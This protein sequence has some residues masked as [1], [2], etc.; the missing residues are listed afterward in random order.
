MPS[1]RS[2]REHR[3]LQTK[4]STR[5]FRV[6]HMQP[7]ASTQERSMLSLFESVLGELYV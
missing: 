4:T 6:D 3:V 7:Q 1:V 5:L 2:S